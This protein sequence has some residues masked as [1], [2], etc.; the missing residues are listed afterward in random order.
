V[1]TWT[2]ILKPI[3]ANLLCV[4]FGFKVFKCLEDVKYEIKPNMISQIKKKIIQ[5]P[6]Y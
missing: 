4:I 2:L 5:V 1:I 6:Y 3:N